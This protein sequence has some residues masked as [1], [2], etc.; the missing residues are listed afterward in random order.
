MEASQALSTVATLQAVV[1]AEA[2]EEALVPASSVTRKVTLLESAP[3][4]T[5]VQA[6]AEVDPE[7]VISATRKVTSRETAQRVVA[8]VAVAT[9]VAT[10]AA[11]VAVTTEAATEVAA[12]AKAVA[13]P[14]VP[15]TTLE[16]VTGTLLAA[17]ETP[18]AGMPSEQAAQD[19]HFLQTR[20]L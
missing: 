13:T 16:A 6:V 20:S 14:G 15:Q 12:S 4:L 19:S 10:T 11:I 1:V 3:M 9:V 2:L 5:P 17:V 18:L 7:P 8:A